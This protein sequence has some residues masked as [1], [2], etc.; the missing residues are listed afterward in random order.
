VVLPELALVVSAERRLR[1]RLS[2]GMV[3]KREIAIDEPDFV[4]VRLFDLL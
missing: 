4:P 2:F 3:G 1:G